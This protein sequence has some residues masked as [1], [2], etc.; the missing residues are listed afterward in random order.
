MSSYIQLATQIEKLKKEAEAARKRE[1][2]ETIAN[3]KRAIELFGLT[4]ED[5][6]LG[7]SGKKR[8]RK[9]SAKSAAKSTGAVKRRGRPPKAAAASSKTARKAG[10]K[11]SKKRGRK[12]AGV[13]KRS[14]VAPKYRDSATGTTWTGRGKQPKWLAA[15]IQSGKKLEDFKI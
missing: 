14:V 15:A 9:A 13:D 5:L 12:A 7:R 3:I 6:G 1:V 10:R 4:A 8:G 11:A 2:A